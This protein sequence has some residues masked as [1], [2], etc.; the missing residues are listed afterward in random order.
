MT[1][2][3]TINIQEVSS[4]LM[5]SLRIIINNIIV[6]IR[7]QDESELLMRQLDD[8][9]FGAQ[10]N[11]DASAAAPSH[12]AAESPKNPHRMRTHQC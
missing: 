9:Y 2:R 12:A 4:S 3:K 6:T 11:S 8:E 7:T 5:W 10:D 1:R